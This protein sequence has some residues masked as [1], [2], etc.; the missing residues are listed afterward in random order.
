MKD[1]LHQIFTKYKNIEN[2]MEGPTADVD[3]L[4]QNIDSKAELEPVL[5]MHA[6]SSNDNGEDIQF[7]TSNCCYRGRGYNNNYR[8]NCGGR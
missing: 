3:R 8:T 6:H 5:H 4:S 7:Y 1:T 2:A